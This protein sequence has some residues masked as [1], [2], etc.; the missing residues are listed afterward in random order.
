MP[1]LPDRPDIDQLRHQARELHRAAAARDPDAIARIGAVS[2]RI[3]LASAQLALAR[4]YGHPS[5][6]ALRREV[7]RLSALRQQPGGGNV[8]DGGWLGRRYS[9]GGGDSLPTAEA[10]LSPGLLSA[11][12][13]HGELDASA[14]LS[15]R[16]VPATAGPDS[17]HQWQSPDFGDLTGTDDEGRVYAASFSAGSI[18]RNRPGAEP[19]PSFLSFRLE[20]APPP[21]AGLIELRAEDGAV[22]HLTRSPQVATRVSSVTAVPASDVARR[23]IDALGYWLLEGWRS[24]PADTMTRECRAARARL[25]ELQPGILDGDAELPREL[26]RLC[27]ALDGH[28]PPRDLPSRWQRFLDAAGEADGPELHLDLATALPRIDGVALQLD[29]LLSRP[30]FWRLYLRV[31]PAWWGR[32]EDGH[33]KW[34]VVAVRA[35]DDRGGRYRPTFG[36]SSAYDEYEEVKLGFRPRIDPLTRRLR[37]IF[38]AGTEEVQAELDLASAAN[39]AARAH[40]A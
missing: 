34:E 12:A 37:L 29:H 15:S 9:F 18:H 14:M 28:Q 17:R 23:D 11:G 25:A 4:E 26:G 10:V 35:E 27:D 31:V 20:P 32:S 6:P 3:S 1:A 38:G 21:S 33:R 36:G 24:D 19:Q 39:P 8:G 22:T 16:P 13:G 7:Q 2:D 40:S 5:W 30:D